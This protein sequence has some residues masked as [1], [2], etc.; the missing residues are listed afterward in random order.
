M[1]QNSTIDSMEMI[2]NST[3][4]LVYVIDLENFE[5]LYANE[6]CKEEFG[7]VIGEVCYKTLQ[8]NEDYTI[9]N[10]SGDSS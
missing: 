3:G 6:R 5:I 10:Y 9:D 1:L 4:A 2:V 8:K 7:E